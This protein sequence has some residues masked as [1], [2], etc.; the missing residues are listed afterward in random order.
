MYSIFKFNQ[1]STVLHDRMIF[2]LRYT[3]YHCLC[4]FIQLR[5]V[6]GI[7]S[8]LTL[9]DEY[10]Q[11]YQ[12]D[13]SFFV[14]YSFFFLPSSYSSIKNRVVCFSYCFLNL[15]IAMTRNSAVIKRKCN[16]IFK[17]SCRFLSISIILF[18]SA[19]MFQFFFSS[20]LFRNYRQTA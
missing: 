17:S 1:L 14:C 13:R 8:A 18:S 7:Q 9:F 3:K 19:Y 2:F 15:K 12:I 11:H 20:G 16:Y 10:S 6:V 4:S 5:H